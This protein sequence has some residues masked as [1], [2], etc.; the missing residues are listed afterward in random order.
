ITMNEIPTRMRYITEEVLQIYLAQHLKDISNILKGENPVGNSNKMRHLEAENESLK[1]ELKM[2]KGNLNPKQPNIKTSKQLK[3][4]TSQ[5]CTDKITESK[6]RV[7]E[8]LRNLAG[9]KPLTSGTK[10]ELKYGY[11]RIFIKGIV[12]QKYSDV[13]ILLKELGF[14]TNRIINL[15]FIGQKILEVTIPGYYAAKFIK[16]IKELEIFEI[17]PKNRLNKAFK[18]TKWQNFANYLYDLAAESG[19]NLGKRTIRNP[20]EIE[21]SDISDNDQIPQLRKK[22]ISIPETLPTSNENSQPNAP[23]ITNLINRS[24]Q[25]INP[26]PADCLRKSSTGKTSF[27]KLLFKNPIVVR[28][29]EDLKKLSLLHDGIIFDDMNF[30]DADREDQIHLLDVEEDSSFDVKYASA[31][32]PKHLPRSDRQQKAFRHRFMPTSADMYHG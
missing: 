12:R 15:E 4:V 1:K 27:A 9:T 14:K 11:S 26:T 21:L 18:A 16:K 17:L 3:I 20:D 2:L 30:A 29:L 31:T 25:I 23:S 28:L 10:A 6:D 13:K 19:I 22:K 32:I 5:A 8:A 24:D 7:Q